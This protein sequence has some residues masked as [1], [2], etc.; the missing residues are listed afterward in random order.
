MLENVFFGVENP[1]NGFYSKLAHPQTATVRLQKVYQIHMVRFVK[2][3]LHNSHFC[4]EIEF[5]KLKKIVLCQKRR[6]MLKIMFYVESR[7]FLG[8]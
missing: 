4:L 6:F 3:R 8:Q 2:R 1:K 5:L 7:A